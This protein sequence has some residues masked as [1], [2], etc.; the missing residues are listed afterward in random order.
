[1]KAKMYI[2]TK[3][4]EFKMNKIKKFD[5]IQG[6]PFESSVKDFLIQRLI[7]TI[8]RRRLERKRRYYCL[9]YFIQ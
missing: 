2:S 4:N 9:T 5:F 7:K 3:R 6:F 8:L 1:M